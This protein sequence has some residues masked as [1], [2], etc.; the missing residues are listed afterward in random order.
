MEGIWYGA[1][2]RPALGRLALAPFSWAFAGIVRARNALFDSGLAQVMQP[3]IPVLSVGNLTAGGTGKTP[4][5]AYFARLMRDAGAAPALVMRGVGN[6]EE[7]TYAELARGVP[8]VIHPDRV[9]AVQRAARN[10]SDV[11]ILDDAFQHRRL[12][13]AVDV[14]LISADRG[15]RTRNLLPS[16]PYREPLSSLRRASLIAVTRKAVSQ[17]VADELGAQLRTL[18]PGIPQARF[19][20]LPE[21]L[22]A[23]RSGARRLADTLHGQRVLAIA[24]IGDPAAFIAQ[25]ESLGA[26]VAPA[27]YGDHHGYTRDDAE[28]L[29]RRGAGFG[30]VVCTLKDA[31]KLAPIWPRQGPE[32][33]YVSQRIEVEEGGQDLD[34]ILRQ[35]LDLRH[36]PER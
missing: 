23:P 10:G 34:R 13:R 2:A 9:R 36:Q 29:A 8:V 27:L 17:D 33:W 25:L 12:G 24:G 3:P 7:R 6:D 16:G 15:L 22:V 19:A 4:L 35:F 31:V 32:L 18:A 30:L 26:A 28:G 20:L 14:V 1:G 21:G 11:A 5:A